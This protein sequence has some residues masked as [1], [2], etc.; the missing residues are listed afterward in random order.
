MA[1]GCAAQ[2]L[3]AHFGIRLAADP[4]TEKSYFLLGF[5]AFLA[6]PNMGEIQHFAVCGLLAGRFLSGASE[7]SERRATGARY[8]Y[9]KT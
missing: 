1:A 4:H 3:G 8:K 5:L 6:Y 7:L 9:W 2:A